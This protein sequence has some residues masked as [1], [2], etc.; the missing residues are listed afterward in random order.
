MSE[1]EALEFAARLR[2]ER[3]NNPTDKEQA[4]KRLKAAGILDKDG[5]VKEYYRKVLA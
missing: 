2:K 5:E 1:K 3:K 4:L